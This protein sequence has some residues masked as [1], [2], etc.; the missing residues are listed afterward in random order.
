[1]DGVG[2]GWREGVAGDEDGGMQLPVPVNTGAAE[3]GMPATGTPPG[4]STRVAPAGV[5]A[6]EGAGG[7][8]RDPAPDWKEDWNSA[9]ANP[10]IKEGDG[11]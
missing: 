3:A 7:R 8:K 5:G 2:V 1:M 10:G 6:R 4:V 9:G 11:R